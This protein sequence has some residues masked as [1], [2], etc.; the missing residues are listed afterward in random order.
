MV[1][2]VGFIFIIILETTSMLR[3]GI[4]EADSTHIEVCKRA[5]DDARQVGKC[6]SE[7]VT[8]VN[9]SGCDIS[10]M[11]IGTANAA[12]MVVTS[13]MQGGSD[14]PIEGLI[15]SRCAEESREIGRFAYFWKVPVIS[16]VGVGSPDVFDNTY[17]PTVVQVPNLSII[18]MGLAL[19]K[20]MD[21]MGQTDIVL[22]GPMVTTKELPPLTYAL[23]LFFTGYSSRSPSSGS[24]P[25]PSFGIN[26]TAYVE[27]DSQNAATVT[28]ASKRLRSPTKMIAVDAG[29]GDS[30]STMLSSLGLVELGGQSYFILLLCPII[31][32]LCTKSAQSVIHSANLIVL[33]PYYPDSDAIN[34][35]FESQFQGGSYSQNALLD[36]YA[37][38]NACFG[39][40]FGLNP[41]KVAYIAHSVSAARCTVFGCTDATL[42]TV[43]DSAWSQS[44]DSKPSSCFYA[45]GCTSILP[46]IAGGLA[47]L[48]I[49]G[50]AVLIY[51]IQRKKRLDVYR[52]HWRIPKQ[53]LKVIENKQ[54]TAWSKRRVLQAYALIGTNKAEF[55]SLKQL[56]KISWDKYELEFIFE[57][58]RLN[59]DNLTNFLG[60][61]Y[62][63]VDRFYLC[64]NLV[65]RGTL[66]DYINDLDFQLDNTF[67]SAFLRDILKG[68]QY[69]HKSAVGFHGLLSL[70]SVLIDTNW[71]LKLTNFGIVNLLNKAIEREQ[72]KMI[73]II[74]LTTYMTAAPE[75]LTDVSYGR[76][77]PHG[78]AVGDI[79]SFGMILYHIL[80]RLAPFDRT[81]LSPKE[82]LEEIKKR[83][84]KPIVENTLPEER[85]LVD[86]MEQCWQ[87]N[88]ELRPKL[89]QLSQV[90]STVFQASQ[91]NLIDQMRR[92]NDKHA[93]NLE[94]LVAQR[95][96][97]LAIAREET[98]RLLHEMLPPSIAK[99]L[100]AQ[101]P[102]EPRNYDSATVLFCQLVDFSVVLS[103]FPPNQV[104][105]YLNQVFTT[106]DNI[107][108]NHDAYKVETT[109]ETYM[110]AS[111]VPNENENRHVFEISEVALEFRESSYNYK[112]E[113]FPDWKLQ[114]R[115]G[116]HCGPIAAGVIGAKA[117]RYCLFGDTVNF[118]SRMQSNCAPNQIQM[119]EATAMM[120][121]KVEKYTLTKRGIVKVKG[122]GDVNTYWLN[123]HVAAPTT[124]SFH[125]Q[126]S[127]TPQVPNQSEP[128]PK[129][130][131]AMRSQLLSTDTLTDQ[132]PPDPLPSPTTV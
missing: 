10:R 130:S 7:P 37:T 95:S 20:F 128:L 51:A 78:S 97:E 9:D 65:E 26:V 4:I 53:Q 90:F 118:A 13:Q 30:L 70:Q 108:R 112:V 46:F 92:M 31:A 35:K 126:V 23:N 48:L 62:N 14:G 12:K 103:K 68:I 89:R 29:M 24:L 115:I 45:G 54:T 120:L 43:D 25:T 71:V 33:S 84:L 38:Y 34:S 111:G 61:S 102:I 72:L 131:N 50:V 15:S 110:V 18:A 109:G 73:E 101:E 3:I 44:R 17:Y 83:N 57:L 60:I 105:D 86:A 16:R 58:K 106:F 80:F 59:H 99:K 49:I 67:R 56:K 40:C 132:P 27:V 63:E 94:N 28:E 22:I 6:G 77:Y 124:S 87:R 98:E 96:A 5:L 117:P 113:N 81:T 41:F 123:E 122:K 1:V 76:T 66:E 47:L 127:A 125:S 64:H 114:L 75:N 85:P 82:I 116:Y 100:K 93:L 32:P 91:G 121:M 69:L 19:K 74:P 119:S 79:Y 36:F 52:M 42:E 55:I 129:I 2:I 21:V 104:I 88:P 11:A 8:L 39:F 107:I